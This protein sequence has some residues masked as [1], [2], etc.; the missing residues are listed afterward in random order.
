MRTQSNHSTEA[1]NFYVGNHFTIPR[2]QL[3]ALAESVKEHAPV[4]VLLL[5]Q[6]LIF[7]KFSQQLALE[8]PLQT[9]FD[10]EFK[11]DSSFEDIVR[12]ADME[13]EGVHLYHSVDID[14]LLYT[15]KL[16]ADREIILDYRELDFEYSQV[17][18][19][20]S[21]YLSYI[22]EYL[23]SHYPTEFQTAKVFL[24]YSHLPTAM[25]ETDKLLNNLKSKEHARTKPASSLS[26]GEFLYPGVTVFI[27][28]NK[29]D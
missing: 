2:Q 14:L 7:D 20:N 10:I 13:H 12:F 15:Q 29:M 23:E 25:A 24:S 28:K 26:K 18:S 8:L 11:F 3:F 4:E 16:L 17:P 9:E 5:Q 22:L 21:P 27:Q 19:V 1:N 6:P